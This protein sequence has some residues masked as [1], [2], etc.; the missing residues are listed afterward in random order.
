M[1]GG[2]SDKEMIRALLE[3]AAKNRKMET[4]FTKRQW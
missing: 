2:D 3:V 4:G 1:T